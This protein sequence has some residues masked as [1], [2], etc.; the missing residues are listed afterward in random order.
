MVLRPLIEEERLG[1]KPKL[2][3][4]KMREWDG[5]GWATGGRAHD[6]PCVSIDP[7]SRSPLACGHP[8]YGWL[9]MAGL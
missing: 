7:K 6:L 5:M 8:S 9:A 1:V 3:A 4:R 2:G